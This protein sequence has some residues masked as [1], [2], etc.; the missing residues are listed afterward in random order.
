M[1]HV[2]FYKKGNNEISGF[3]IKGH[4]GY[5][6]EGADIVCAAVSALAES[7][8]NGI[9]TLTDAK[10]SEETVKEEEGYLKFILSRCSKESD[11]LLQ[12]ME[13]GIKSISGSYPEFVQVQN[14]EETKC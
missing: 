8:V 14:E 13:L 6:D 7:T 4:S 2:T 11:L 5:A 1:I 3:L 12:N 9:E 10:V